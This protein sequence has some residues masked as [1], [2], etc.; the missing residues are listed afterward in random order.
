MSTVKSFLKR[1]EERLNVTQEVYLE[2]FEEPFVIQATSNKENERLAKNFRKTR[3]TK[4]GKRESVLDDEAYGAALVVRSIVTP[5]LQNAEL[6][7]FYGTQGDA[8]ATLKE[9]ISMGEYLKL[10][11]A[12]SKLNGFDEDDEEVIEEVKK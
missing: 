4:G 5:D 8:I 3:I 12:I 10:Q 7:E 11:N 2:G 6:Q 1:R 9:M